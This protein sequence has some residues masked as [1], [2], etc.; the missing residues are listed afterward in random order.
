MFE[1]MGLL[2]TRA[3]WSVAGAGSAHHQPGFEQYRS[4]RA[5]WQRACAEA[6]LPTGGLD[7]GMPDGLDE[8]RNATSILLEGADPPTALV[9]VSDSIALGAWTELTRRGLRPG[10][11]LAIVGFD[12]SPTAEVIGL[13]SAAQPLDQVATACL[14]LLHTV[15]NAAEPAAVPPGPVLLEPRLMVRA[16][17]TRD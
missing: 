9:C 6:G 17:S 11:D 2:L 5:G 7:L 1:R 4:G 15:L 14:S 10:R 13:S 8:G 16:S 12:D 3:R